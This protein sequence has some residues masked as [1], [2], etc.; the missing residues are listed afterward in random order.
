MDLAVFD[1]TLKVCFAAFAETDRVRRQ[2][3]LLR[4]LTEDAEIWG[5][6]RVF[7]GYSSISDKIDGFHCRKPVPESWPARLVPWVSHATPCCST[8]R[9][10]EET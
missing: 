7:K 4:C 6:Q 3:L 2:E 10:K 1:A 5:P 9:L 8:R